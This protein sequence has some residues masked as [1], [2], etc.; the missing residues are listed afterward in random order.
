VKAVDWIGQT[1]LHCAGDEQ[2]ARLLISHGANVHAVYN[3]GKTPLHFA[4]AIGIAKALIECGAD[5]R[6]VDNSGRSTFDLLYIVE[7]GAVETEYD[8]GS[9]S[10]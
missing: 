9:Y 2:K 10:D 4:R 8:S 7:H 3:E 1:P 5:A 6:A